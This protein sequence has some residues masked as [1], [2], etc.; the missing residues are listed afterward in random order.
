MRPKHGRFP[1]TAALVATL[2]L[3][4]AVALPRGAFADAVVGQPA[5]AFTLT[6]TDGKP[7]ALAD[8][9]GKYVVLEWINHDCPFVKKH[10]G[11]GNM[12][13]LQKKYTEQGVVWLSVNSSAPG[14]QGNYP[15]E[16]A[17]ALTKEKNAAPT[18]LLLDPDGTVGKAYGAKTTPHM[19]VIDP[20][21]TLVY[22]G[23]IDD[24]PSTDPADI[25]A[26]RNHV[27]QALGEA[28]A[29]KPVTVASSTPYG[30]SV[31]Y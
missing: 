27:D 31:K 1:R 3:A 7:H 18:A 6:G 13:K 21:G 25:A 2:A 4:A 11:S 20:K 23:G 15:P 24:K 12:Q 9:Q 5:P 22:A 19:Y 29:G 8:Y 10:Y 30:C 16:Q 28:L 26:A 14:K 17:N